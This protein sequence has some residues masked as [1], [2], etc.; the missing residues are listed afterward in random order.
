MPTAPRKKKVVR[1]PAS[2]GRNRPPARAATEVEPAESP[3]RMPTLEAVL[4]AFQKS[5]AR[6]GRNATHTARADPE[7]SGGLRT[8]YVVDGLDVEL[9]AGLHT[10]PKARRGSEGVRVDFEAPADV[11]SRL[12]F[13]LQSQPMPALEGP[14]LELAELDPLG[15]LHPRV[16][17]RVVLIGRDGRGLA[18]Q[19]VFLSFLK[20]G[21]ATARLDLPV[22]T[23]RLGRV[24]FSVEMLKSS[25][26]ITIVG[27]LPV[28]PLSWAGDLFIEATCTVLPPPAEV[29][30]R[31]PAGSDTIPPAGAA[32]DVPGSAPDTRHKLTSN[33]V[34][35]R[36]YRKE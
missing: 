19:E 21:D 36:A 28:S 25:V 34:R 30:A 2:K 32:D 33:V 20:A 11:R 3:T 24:D 31:V 9:V 14:Q 5:L 16:P 26:S 23:D 8:V 13:R 7:F 22:R 29:P 27:T 6:A 15:D 12:R 1:G 18:D 35:V 17:L 4:V 10:D